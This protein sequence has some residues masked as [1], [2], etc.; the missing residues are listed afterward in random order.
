MEPERW[1]QI[2]K[3]LGEA[4][5]L[6][7]SRRAAF[8]DQ[9]CAGDEEL[10][11]KI[12]AL[13]A[14]HEHA[15]SFIEAPAFAGIA[16]SLADEARSMV[17]RQLG[18]YQVLA[19][20][21]AGGMGAVWK[22]KDTRLDREV[23][24]KTLPQGFDQHRDSLARFEREAKLLASL[25]HPN[26]A[27]IHG[28]D[29][30]RGTRFLVLEL[31]EGETLADRLQH[32]AIALEESLKL[33][34]QISEALEAAHEK[35][36]IHR[37]LKP[38]NI[39]IT[40]DGT[41]KILDFG[42]AKAFARDDVHADL[43]DSPSL[44][45]ESTEQG[46][47]LGT[48][49]YMAPEQARGKKVDRR[50]DIWA[51][52]VV[53][54]EMVTGTRPFRG[55]DSTET[56]A[57]VVMKE[58]DFDAVPAPVRRLLRKCLEKDPK[59]RLRD[60]GDVWELL[61]DPT[62]AADAP[63]PQAGRRD[64]V[65]PWIVASVLGIV[66]IVFSFLWL[67]PLPLPEVGRFQIQAPPGGRLPLGTPAISND[68]R[69]L[70][71]TVVDPDGL[72]RIHMRAID[73][74]ESR[75]LPGTEGA[76]H[77]F[78]S[79]S[80]SSLAFVAGVWLKRIDLAGES[81]RDLISINGVWPGAWNQKDDI[82]VRVRQEL[83]RISTQ[84]APTP[85]P[86][87]SDLVFPA[88]LTDGQR[89]LVGVGNDNRGS[90]QL[91]A[92]D[93]TKRT[94][95]VDNVL[96]A[97]VLAPTPRGKTYLL[98]LRESNLMAQRFD[99]ASGKVL[100]DAVPL[101]PRI[102]RLGLQPAMPAVGASPSGIL[103]YQNAD[104][105]TTRQLR[106]VDRSGL[107]LRT[108]SPDLLV[109][110]PR[111]SPDQSSFAGARHGDIW[112]TDLVRESSERKTFDDNREAFPVWSPDGSRLAFVAN[113][114]I[115]TVGVN[116]DGKPKLV[117][118]THGIP[119]SWSRRHLL[120]IVPRPGKIYL[121]DVAGGQKPVQV[122]SP[123]GN[124]FSGEF[125]PDGNYIA[126][127]SDKSGR[128]E[129]YVQPI[130][131][132]AGEARVSINGG[133]VPRWRGDGK[134]IFFVSLDGHLMAVDIKLGGTISVGIPHKLFRFDSRDGYE[135]GR[136]GYDVTRDGQRF[137]IVSPV[138][139]FNSPITVVLNWWVELEKRRGQ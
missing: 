19:L 105:V 130:R 27:A 16:Q 9:A 85:I 137:L 116:G 93:S 36:I 11:R 68:G 120:Y 39:K 13:L 6:E 76:V 91:G 125:S 75:A 66:A 46:M 5:E 82:L 63:R 61:N 40:A 106:W 77:P 71:Y 4:L 136:N 98:F 14:A 86:N 128:L 139:E 60:I 49:A 107:P 21:G 12:D 53:L 124:S 51:F 134:E 131:P 73:G 110:G 1:Q 10:R 129:V 43:S 119:M 109:E 78:W 99:E 113:G 22:A 8:L 15:E 56:M 97:P 80:G 103:A 122:G 7:V 83:V 96:S 69:T 38:A 28:L 127:D 100:G 115:Y 32:G 52:G 18:H 30:D 118:E 138:K 87:S 24:I 23:A 135:V 101:V 31:V 84:G 67:K 20:V 59:N 133:G 62:V 65:L 90:I 33:A 102:A 54:Y 42:L 123:S 92:L 112:V 44:S 108:L 121:L 70:A 45:V 126:F 79:P 48:A 26:I 132:G 50:V 81:I 104:Q 89:Y 47:I 64:A 37:D 3:L 25:N 74:L 95:V 2:D 94:L 17:G 41:A 34:R 57:S 111:L 29:E 35:G 88:F 117:T 58:P 55:A 114:G 72:T